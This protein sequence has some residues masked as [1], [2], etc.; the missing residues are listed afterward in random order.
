MADK[1]KE[2]LD[3][4]IRQQ[5]YAVKGVKQVGI[6]LKKVN[7]EIMDPE[8]ACIVVWVDKKIDASL[9]GD[10]QMVPKSFIWNDHV[11]L[12]DVNESKGNWTVS[13]K[14]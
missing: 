12:T 4:G 13:N 5:L 14:T 9:L 1:C 6:A 8:T 2:L 11:I 7:G 10:A 3:S